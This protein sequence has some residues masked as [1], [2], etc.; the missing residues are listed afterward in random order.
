MYRISDLEMTNFPRWIQNSIP[1][2]RFPG[3]I[4]DDRKLLSLGT[5]ECVCVCVCDW[6]IQ[7]TR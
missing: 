7:T 5:P 3:L 4:N 1:A 6:K 2:L